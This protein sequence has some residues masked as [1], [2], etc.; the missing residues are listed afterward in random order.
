MLRAI[1]SAKSILLAT[2][3]RRTDP[4]ASATHLSAVQYLE[5]REASNRQDM[6]L[7]QNRVSDRAVFNI[8]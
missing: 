2:T 4:E 1:E 8:Q 3:C 6:K 7:T 5:K